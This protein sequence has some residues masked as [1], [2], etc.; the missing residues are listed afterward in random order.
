MGYLFHVIPFLVALIEYTAVSSALAFAKFAADF[1]PETVWLLGGIVNVGGNLPYNAVPHAVII[2]HLI[3]LM[4]SVTYIVYFMFLRVS[5][6]SKI[7]QQVPPQ[8]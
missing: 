1:E 3:A 5:F 6:G 7:E 2:L 4:L 8:Q